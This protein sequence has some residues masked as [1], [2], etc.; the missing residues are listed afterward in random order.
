MLSCRQ[1]ENEVCFK[2]C[3]IS[4]FVYR[5]SNKKIYYQFFTNSKKET[6][7]HLMK[8]ILLGAELRGI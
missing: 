4:E 5:F 6:D 7:F 2:A 3:G 8:M 1:L